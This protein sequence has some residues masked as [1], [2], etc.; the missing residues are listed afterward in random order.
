[1]K[2]MES[3][4][5][6]KVLVECN[7]SLFSVKSTFQSVHRLAKKVYNHKLAGILI[8]KLMKVT[9]DITEYQWSETMPFGKASPETNA[10]IS[11]CLSL[12]KGHSV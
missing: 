8:I 3:L 6:E 2:V 4:V 7:F 9:V 11:L 5:S 10:C 12:A 1:M